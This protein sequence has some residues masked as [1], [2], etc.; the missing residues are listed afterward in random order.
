VSARCT[1]DGD[2]LTLPCGS[3]GALAATPDGTVYVSSEAGVR[4]YR[5][6]GGDGCALALDAAFGVGG[7]LKPPEKAA[8]PQV[9]GKGTVMLRSGGPDWQVIADG[10]AVYLLDFLLGLYR[11]DRGKAAPVCPDLQGASALAIRGDTAVAAI[12]HGQR[13]ALRKRCKATALELAPRPAFGVFAVGDGVWGKTGGGKLTRYD[14][15]GKAVATIG[16]E[17]AFAPGGLCSTA[18]VG[19]C[20]DDVCVL[21][22]NCQK[23]AR[24]AADGTFRVERE[25]RQLFGTVP[26]GLSG[27]A[28]AADGGLWVL[29]K[30]KDGETCEAAIYRVPGAAI[31]P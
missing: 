25:A 14:R 26:Y 31:A 12:D 30:L 28:P 16:G 24:F 5:P 22:T 18:A 6:S 1:L 23:L 17:D 19:A 20:G 15:A 3:G 27:L 8:K 7:T 9:L 4:R 29:A 2:P 13:L 11:I 10:D 21:D